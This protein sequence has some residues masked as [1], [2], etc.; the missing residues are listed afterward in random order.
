ME[1][2]LSSEYSFRLAGQEILP[3]FMDLIFIM[4]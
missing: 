1:Q 4:V 2:R 3:P